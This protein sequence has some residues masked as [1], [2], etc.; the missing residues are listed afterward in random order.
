MQ[1]HVV[2]EL[3]EK[4]TDIINDLILD[5][6][7]DDLKSTSGQLANQY[8]VINDE[9]AI[10]ANCSTKYKISMLRDLF[11]RCGLDL[12]ELGLSLKVN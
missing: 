8:H 12:T 11:S 3:Y 1:I 9:F 6:T 2:N 7:F 5:Q 4:F 10:Y